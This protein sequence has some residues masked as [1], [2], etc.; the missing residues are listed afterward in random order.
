MVPRSSSRKATWGGPP[1]PRPASRPASERVREDPRGPGG[2]PHSETDY[3][4]MICPA[5]RSEK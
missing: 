1:G 5:V 2:P 4:V 3:I